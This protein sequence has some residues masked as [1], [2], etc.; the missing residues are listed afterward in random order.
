MLRR[1]ALEGAGVGVGVEA[2]RVIQ[3][4]LVRA[5]SVMQARSYAGRLDLQDRTLVIRR[6][7][8][9]L[10]YGVAAVVVHNASYP[11]AVAAAGIVYGLR[12]WPPTLFFECCTDYV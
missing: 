12:S 10:H 9:P 5:Q 3:R 11:A 6:R 2:L 1:L 8:F 7:F 4:Q